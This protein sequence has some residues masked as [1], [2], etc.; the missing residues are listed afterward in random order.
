[1]L[2]YFHLEKLL[3]QCSHDHLKHGLT[4]GEPYLKKDSMLDRLTT[5]IL[6]ITIKRKS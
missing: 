2:I 6:S 3:P 1:M 4:F 5:W